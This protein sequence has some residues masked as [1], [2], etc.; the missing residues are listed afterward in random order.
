MND[1]KTETKTDFEQW[2]EKYE[3]LVAE[4][5]KLKQG[6]KYGTKFSKA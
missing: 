2:K 5:E 3:K 1:Y 4:N 6:M